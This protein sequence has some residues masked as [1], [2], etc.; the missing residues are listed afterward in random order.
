MSMAVTEVF[1]WFVVIVQVVAANSNCLW[2][3]LSYFYCPF[4]FDNPNKWINRS[5]ARVFVVDYDDW[6][7]WHA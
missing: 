3:T 5:R 1:I 2:Q 7:K 6:N 4:D